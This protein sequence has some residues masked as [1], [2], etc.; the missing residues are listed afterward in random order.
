MAGPEC[1]ATWVFQR[2]R[3]VPASR[4][5]AVHLDRQQRK[6]LDVWGDAPNDL[7]E[8]QPP[9]TPMVTVIPSK[10][11][12]TAAQPLTV[13]VAVSGTPTPT[14][15]VTLTSGSYTSAATTLSGGSATINI[16][17]GSLATGSDTLTAS[18]TPDSNSSSIYNSASGKSTTVKVT[19]AS[20]TITFAT[21][22]AQKVGTPLTLSVT[23]SS[24][25]AVSFTSTTPGI[26][27]VSGA[28]AT[29]VALGTC[30][31]DANQPGNSTYAA[32][33]QVV[34]SFTV[35]GVAQTITFATIPER[36]RWECR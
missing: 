14:G 16:P 27:T 32:A 7:W 2:P 15:S 36:R 22:P 24:G 29:F 35:T 30:S 13:T 21:I 20:Q 18:Y 5:A 4:E 3:D 9:A 28:T 17:A 1:M 34:R 33:P 23:A 12:I 6:P 11:S 26:C 10:S 8:Y 25:L 19:L 31:I